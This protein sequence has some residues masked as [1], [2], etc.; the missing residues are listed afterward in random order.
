MRF[1]S[2][3]VINI[4]PDSK[5]LTEEKREKLLK[6]MLK[7]SDWLAY[8]IHVISPMEITEKMLSRWFY[9][10]HCFKFLKLVT[11]VG[12]IPFQS[13]DKSKCYL[14]ECSNWSYK[15]GSRSKC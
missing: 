9:M 7:K 6:E 1:Y 5:Q 4:E 8:T 13:K 3:I 14:T 12:F 2:R 10:P 11:Y 15:I